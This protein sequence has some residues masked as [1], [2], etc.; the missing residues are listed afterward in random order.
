M[1]DESGRDEVYVAL[2]PGPGGK[3]RVSTAGGTFPKWRGR[4]IFYLARE[5][6]LMVAEVKRQGAAPLMRIVRRPR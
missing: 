1:S 3:L 6:T 4:E 5:N 2:F